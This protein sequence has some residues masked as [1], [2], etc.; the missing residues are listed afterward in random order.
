MNRKF[1][2]FQKDGETWL[3]EVNPYRFYDGDHFLS[4]AYIKFEEE[5]LSNAKPLIGNFPV[6]DEYCESDLRVV[7]QFKTPSGRWHNADMKYWNRYSY[8]NYVEYWSTGD[9][10]AI[11]REAYEYIGELIDTENKEFFKAYDEVQSELEAAYTVE[12]NRIIGLIEEFK[13]YCECELGGE[14][15]SKKG[16]ENNKIRIEVCMGLITKI[17]QS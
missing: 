7:F 9:I 4:F 11:T 16:E 15:L 14:I 12:R 2:P 6:K 10:T 17:K 8:K 5:S 3:K 13:E 1:Q